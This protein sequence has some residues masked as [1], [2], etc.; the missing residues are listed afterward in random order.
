MLKMT[1]LS[2][3]ETEILLTLIDNRLLSNTEIIVQQGL[4]KTLDTDTTLLRH[5]SSELLTISDKLSK[6]ATD[7]TV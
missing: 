1:K 4:S 7:G 3:R 2:K 6:Q 5:F